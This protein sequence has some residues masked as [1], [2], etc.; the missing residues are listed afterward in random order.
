M[1]GGRGEASIRDRGSDMVSLESF[2]LDPDFGAA[3][4]G[5]IGRAAHT[6]YALELCEKLC[7]PR[8]Q[9]HGVFALLESMLAHL[10]RGTPISSRLRIFELSLLQRLGFAA[11]IDRCVSCGLADF[12]RVG[13]GISA[14]AGGLIC[15]ACGTHESLN[16]EVLET[17]ARL[18]VANLDE[19]E[20]IVL[21]PATNASCREIAL[22]LICQHTSSPLKS[23]EF[24]AK[25]CA[26]GDR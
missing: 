16:P 4:D 14:N 19:A 26:A 13:A 9:E 5:D 25:M 1:A 11:A 15:Q 18:S 10:C 2:V 21:T 20:S 12:S 22:Q 6:A 17:L 24:V 8:H 7:A 23:L 3:P